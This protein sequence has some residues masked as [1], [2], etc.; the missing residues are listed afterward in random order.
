MREIDKEAGLGFILRFFCFELLLE[1]AFLL[2]F[3]YR[4][5][6]CSGSLHEVS[7]TVVERCPARSI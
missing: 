3:I 5:K 2:S 1:H 7:H 6:F 4:Y